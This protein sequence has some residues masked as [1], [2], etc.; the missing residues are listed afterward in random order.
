M[1]DG[2]CTSCSSS[3]NSDATSL[4]QLSDQGRS[5]LEEALNEVPKVATSKKQNFA[6][7]IRLT[8][9]SIRQAKKA[10]NY[11][12]LA[13]SYYDLS[14]IKCQMLELKGQI[15]TAS[16]YTVALGQVLIAKHYSKKKY[17]LEKCDQLSHK[18][19]ERIRKVYVQE[20]RASKEAFQNVLCATTT[21]EGWY[22][23]TLQSIAP[24]ENDQDEM[25]EMCERGHAMIPQS[26]LNCRKMN[27]LYDV[28]GRKMLPSAQNFFYNIL[29]PASEATNPLCNT[30]RTVIS[31]DKPKLFCS[32]CQVF[33]C[34]TC[35]IKRSQKM[36]RHTLMNPS[37]REIA[38][39]T[40]LQ[41]VINLKEKISF[42]DL[43]ASR[44]GM[45]NGIRPD[46]PITWD[47]D[48]LRVVNDVS[49][50]VA[51]R[52]LND[53]FGSF[54]K[55]SFSS[56]HILVPEVYS[57][58]NI[59]PNVVVCRWT[60][61]HYTLYDEFNFGGSVDFRGNMRDRS[62]F[63]PCVT[64]W[65]T[66]MS[67][68]AVYSHTSPTIMPKYLRP[69]LPSNISSKR[70]R[71]EQTQIDR[72][73]RYLNENGTSLDPSYFFPTWKNLL[74]SSRHQV[75]K[76]CMS[77]MAR[78]VNGIKQPHSK[79]DVFHCNF[80][81]PAIT[82]VLIHSLNTIANQTND[83]PMPQYWNIIDPN[84][85]VSLQKVQY[86]DDCCPPAESNTSQNMTS[87]VVH[88]PAPNISKLQWIATDVLV[89][90]S[91]FP[92]YDR[93]IALQICAKQIF[94]QAG[95]KR[96]IC[97]PKHLALHIFRYMPLNETVRVG[98]AKI[99]SK[100]HWMKPINNAPFYVSC[101]K[102]LTAALPMLGECNIF[103]LNDDYFAY[104]FLLL[105]LS[106]FYKSFTSSTCFTFTW[107]T[108]S[109]C[110][111]TAYDIS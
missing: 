67:G 36:R 79:L 19:K 42:R 35:I 43:K 101:E 92:I 105:V 81:A 6:E 57:S 98:R 9:S 44:Q 103:L 52:L 107:T 95:R 10:K 30:C 4:R 70:S 11:S 29:K 41:D 58:N 33:E 108:S 40:R 5:L 88:G 76:E 16:E 13:S 111:I 109:C 34:S 68:G 100:I 99:V 25:C 102:I 45:K 74:I 97:L 78:R 75:T 53:Y 83:R 56:D 60:R 38:T 86:N 20:L 71:N 17:M 12:V 106:F 93:L 48:M 96:G 2:T 49:E 32:Q 85:C 91:V 64:H 47:K 8:R 28:V 14:N 55:D 94:I 89:T 84:M 27:K 72:M 21:I 82:E 62:E 23:Y 110:K 18:I 26:D 39:S 50:D 24:I 87:T 104:K 1:I 54:D 59:R 80:V 66:Q 73:Y 51:D 31:K 63:R 65:C 3:K 22:A 15:S 46:N 77:G 37:G 61:N 90:E 7:S 69:F